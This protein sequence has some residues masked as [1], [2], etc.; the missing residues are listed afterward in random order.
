M[1]RYNGFA[2]LDGQE[3]MHVAEKH[4]D[5]RRVDGI[6]DS[7]VAES[8]SDKPAVWDPQNA[9]QRYLQ[10]GSASKEDE[11]ARARARARAGASAWARA[12]ASARAISLYIDIYLCV[13]LCIAIYLAIYTAIYIDIIAAVFVYVYT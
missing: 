10:A 2:A 4:L 1:A 6:I 13:A 11:R 8:V 3:G 9:S 5:R 12:R 7:G